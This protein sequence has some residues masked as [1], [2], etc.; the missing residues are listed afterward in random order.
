M[1]LAW[2]RMLVQAS[3][4]CSRVVR[5]ETKF[6]KVHWSPWSFCST[7]SWTWFA[8]PHLKLITVYQCCTRKRSRS[9]HTFQQKIMC[10]V[11]VWIKFFFLNLWQAHNICID[12]SVHL[13]TVLT[14]GW[15]DFRFPSM[16]SW[17]VM[18]ASSWKEEECVQYA[19]FMYILHMNC[20]VC[21]F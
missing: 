19:Q 15:K 20:A 16:L 18:M 3:P 5:W 4:T 21:I 13:L 17:F 9:G 6:S 2:E 7:T 11:T 8:S 1:V 14:T 12:S 10:D